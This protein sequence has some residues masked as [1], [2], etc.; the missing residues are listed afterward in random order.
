MPIFEDFRHFYYQFQF[1]VYSRLLNNIACPFSK[2]PVFK[3]MYYFETSSQTE[4]D[5]YQI[6]LQICPILTLS[7][8]LKHSRYIQSTPKRN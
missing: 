1:A 7:G 5:R 6:I 4:T 8:D 3:S 2:R